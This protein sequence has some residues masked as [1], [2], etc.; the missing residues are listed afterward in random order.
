[1]QTAGTTI[2]RMLKVIPSDD[3]NIPYPNIVFRDEDSQTLALNDTTLYNANEPF[4]VRNA[5]GEWVNIVNPGDIIYFDDLYRAATI[6]EVTN[7]GTIIINTSDIFGTG[8]NPEYTIY[9]ESTTPNQGCLLYFSDSTI[10]PN[11]SITSAGGDFEVNGVGFPL[12]KVKSQLLPMQV[13]KLWR[14]DTT[15]DVDFYALW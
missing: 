6:I 2:T 7:A 10:T 14:R 13:I 15:S 4:Q 1:M 8:D 3:C 9:Q 5:Y 11:M 12:N